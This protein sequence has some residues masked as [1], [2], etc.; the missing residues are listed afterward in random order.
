MQQIEY[1]QATLNDIDL[2]VKSRIDFM[3]DYWGEVE[4][5]KQEV[6]SKCLFDFF[7]TEIQGNTYITWFAFADGNFAGVGGMKVIKKP[8]SFRVPEGVTGYIMNMYTLPAYR[9]R[10]IATNI[11]KLLEKTGADMGIRFF[12]LHATDDGRPVYEKEGYKLHN[13]PTMRKLK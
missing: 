6:L 4:K 2:L 5:D 9:K 1:R 12:E 8:G 11:L 10:G 3:K 13:E 7:R